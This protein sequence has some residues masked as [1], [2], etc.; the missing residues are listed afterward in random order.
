MEALIDGGCDPQA[1]LDRP[2]FRIDG[3]Q[4]HLEEG[5]WEYADELGALGL[6]P[7]LSNDTTIFGG[8]QLILTN[9]DGLLGGSDARRDGY[10]AGI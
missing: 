1:A 8:G 4:I 3:S 9:G 7:V 6:T 2:R 10:A 5:L